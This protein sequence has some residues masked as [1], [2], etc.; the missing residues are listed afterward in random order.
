MEHVHAP[1]SA[2]Q[3]PRCSATIE[4]AVVRHER[5]HWILVYGGKTCR[6]HD[7]QGLPV[8][9]CLLLNPGKALSA[10]ELQPVGLDDSSETQQVD[11]AAGERARIN[12]TRAVNNAIERI[13]LHH[14]D[15]YLHL[16]ATVR[17]GSLCSYSPD[18]SVPILWVTYSGAAR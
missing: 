12:V 14:P 13:R 10:T 1:A 8:L 15:L 16:R 17:T 7:N 4:G 2:G 18:M 11:S 6:V 9:E 3:K 5:D